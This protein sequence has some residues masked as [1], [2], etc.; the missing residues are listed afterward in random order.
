MSLPHVV[1]QT[2]DHGAVAFLEHGPAIP[3]LLVCLYEDAEEEHHTPILTAVQA[4]F[5]NGGGWMK[6]T[7]SILTL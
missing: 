1:I 5:K 6:K 2:V 3:V 7:K 4:Y